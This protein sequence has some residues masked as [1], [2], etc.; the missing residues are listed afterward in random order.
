LAKNQASPSNTKT[1]VN[2][3]IF[4]NLLGSLNPGRFDCSFVI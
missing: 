4:S 1:F 3:M 2:L